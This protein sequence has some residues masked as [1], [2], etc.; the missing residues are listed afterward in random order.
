MRPPG[1]GLGLTVLAAGESGVSARGA[2]EA[3]SMATAFLA[4]GARSVVSAQ[5]RVPDEPTSVLMLLFHH[6]VREC[7]M[8][9]MDAL[10][11]AQ[12][13]MVRDEPSPVALPVAAHIDRADS[14]SLLAWAGFIHF[15][16]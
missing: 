9:A 8:S 14:R 13:W 7:G 5:W 2:D 16:R 11:A 4:N 3:F 15:G 6:Y 1:D 12:L 10:R